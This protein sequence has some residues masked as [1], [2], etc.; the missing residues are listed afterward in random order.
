MNLNKISANDIAVS[1]LKVQR[2][3]MNVIANNIANVET[4]RTPEGGVFQRQMVLLLGDEIKPGANPERLGVRVK[5]VIRDTS[6]PRMVFDPQHPD[7]N[8]EGMVAYPNIN[9]AVEMVN[10][11]S[12][13]RAYEANI[14]VITSGRQMKQRALDILQQ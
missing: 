11:I 3:R 7:A 1:G 14:A 2:A 4:T 10:L 5:D 9:T 6:P 13:Q 12:A 8:E